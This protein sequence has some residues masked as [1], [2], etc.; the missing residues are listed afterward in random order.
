MRESAMVRNLKDITYKDSK[1][2][3][4]KTQTVSSR[5]FLRYRNSNLMV[6][7]IHIREGTVIQTMERL[8]DEFLLHGKSN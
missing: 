6:W 4:Q 7:I 2:M 3:K 5:V 1:T 8:E